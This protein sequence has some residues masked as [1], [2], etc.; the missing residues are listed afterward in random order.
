M[1]DKKI[2]GTGGDQY[3]PFEK[4]TGEESKVYFTRDL[5]AS[6]LQKFLRQ[7]QRKN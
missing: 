2:P 4:R 5:S 7:L 6:G 1:S 3:I